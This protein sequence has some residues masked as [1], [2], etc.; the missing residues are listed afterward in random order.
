MVKK[1]SEVFKIERKIL[2]VD[3][4]NAFLS[5]TAVDMLANGAEIDIRKIPAVIGGDEKTR[6]GIVLAKSIAAKKMKI[7]TGESLFEARRKC[8]NLQVFASDFQLYRKM[9]NAMIT[10]LLEYTDRIERFSIDEC[11]LDLTY[12]VKNDEELIEKANAI[13]IRI[14]DELHFTVNI[15]VAHNKL[16]AKMASDFEK[17]D[18]VHTLFETEIPKKMWK[19]PVEE[20]FMVGKKSAPKLRK[21]GITTIGILAQKEKEFMTQRFGKLGTLLWEYANGIDFTEVN[22]EEEEPKSIGNSITLPFDIKDKERLHQVVLTLT[23]QVAFRLRKQNLLA[24]VVNVQIKTK[25]FQVFS[26]QRKLDFPTDETKEI[27]ILAKELLEEIQ[28]NYY[29]RLLGVR[30][31][32]LVSKEEQQISFFNMCENPKEKKLDSVMDKIKQKY[33]YHSIYH[34]GSLQE[35]SSKKY[36]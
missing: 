14:K 2:H 13:S 23:E 10:I 3:V 35:F 12:C 5:W 32:N 36:Q 4:N 22:S 21:L 18:R 30:V 34:A 29:I 26:H 16:L 20:L 19:L 7:T 25:E 27:Y 6:K 9:S 17:P 15:G 24:S 31:D 28:K 1:E 8:P 33:G 11:F